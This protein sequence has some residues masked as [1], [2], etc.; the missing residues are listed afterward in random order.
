MSRQASKKE[1]CSVTRSLR[2]SKQ[3][4]AK[5][6]LV[7]ITHYKQL[8]HYYKFSN[9]FMFKEIPLRKCLKRW[10]TNFFPNSHTFDM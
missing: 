7:S 4:L 2:S 6:D 5:N 9:K 8:Q 3:K 10:A 1:L